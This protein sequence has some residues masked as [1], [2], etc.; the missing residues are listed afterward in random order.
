MADQDTIDNLLE[1]LRINRATLGLYLS[2]RDMLGLANIRPEIAIGIR[3]SRREIARIKDAL[4][5]LQ[6]PFEDLPDDEEPEPEPDLLEESSDH[7]P[8]RSSRKIVLAVGTLTLVVALLV[9]GAIITQSMDPPAEPAPPERATSSGSA[10]ASPAPALTPTAEPTDAPSPMESTTAPSPTPT[11]TEPAVASTVEP[12]ATATATPVGLITFV[13]QPADQPANQIFAMHDD[14]L[15]DPACLTCDLD[16]AIYHQQPAWSPNGN[17]LALTV[18]VEVAVDSSQ[19]V[20]LLDLNGDLRSLTANVPGSLSSPSWSPDGNWLVFVAERDGKPYL[21]LISAE[22]GTEQILEF[23][24]QQIV[25]L[26]PSWSP[27]GKRIAYVRP[28]EVESDIYS[29]TLN[30]RRQVIGQDKLTN[31]VAR[32]AGPVWSPNGMQIAFHSQRGG[33]WDIY[34]MDWQGENERPLTTSSIQEYQPAWSPDGTQIAYFVDGG[35]TP[36]RGD[37]FVIPSIGGTARRLTSRGDIV[38]SRIDWSSS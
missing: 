16:P 5:E 14:G 1:R 28:L 8:G 35:L 30:E 32:D 6:V 12:T 22:G 9:V 36:G 20:A 37:L 15:G 4:R 24:D 19:N 33:S 7:Q 38:D 21:A 25:G 27:D 18:P 17:L 2:Q 11:P 23:G 10:I 34:I 31:S 26:Q 13:A 29:L 3:E